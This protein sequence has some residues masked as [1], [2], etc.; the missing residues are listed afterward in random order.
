MPAEPKQAAI[1][2]AR[3]AA[4]A[5]VRDA[6]D[7]LRRCLHTTAAMHG[8]RRSTQGGREGGRRRGERRRPLVGKEINQSGIVLMRIKRPVNPQ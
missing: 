7:A 6:R 8:E 5:S 1:A 4:V 2:A 3:Y